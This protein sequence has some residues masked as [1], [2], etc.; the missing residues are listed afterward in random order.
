MIY[1]HKNILL[2]Y[3]KIQSIEMY[4]WL[5]R[6]RF[7]NKVY[8]YKMGLK[9]FTISEQQKRFCYNLTLTTFNLTFL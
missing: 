5:E 7:I 9:N 3:I 6:N 1:P 4:R 8:M 2:V